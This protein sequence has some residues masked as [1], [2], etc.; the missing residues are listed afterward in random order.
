MIF[1]PFGINVFHGSKTIQGERIHRWKHDRSGSS[2]KP[3]GRRLRDRDS[4]CDEFDVPETSYP[5]KA[6]GG[7]PRNPA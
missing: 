7:Q 5:L 4:G 6:K 2:Q 1:D 3:G